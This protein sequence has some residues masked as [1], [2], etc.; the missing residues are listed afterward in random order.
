MRVHWLGVATS[1][2]VSHWLKDG[3]AM[4]VM[5]FLR[6]QRRPVRLR[7]GSKKKVAESYECLGRREVEMTLRGRRG[8]WKPNNFHGLFWMGIDSTGSTGQQLSKWASSAWLSMTAAASNVLGRGWCSTRTRMLKRDCIL[9]V[10]RIRDCC[11][12]R[13][14]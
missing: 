11:W 3:S 14:T 6:W 1:C 7:N 4:E 10:R 12:A 9:N 8:C 2:G 13:N 5:L